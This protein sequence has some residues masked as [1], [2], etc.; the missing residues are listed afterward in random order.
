MWGSNVSERVDGGVVILDHMAV[1]PRTLRVT[2]TRHV[3]EARRSVTT[4]IQVSEEMRDFL[5]GHGTR[6]LMN[7]VSKTFS[8]ISKEEWSAVDNELPL[9]PLH[10]RE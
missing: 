6:F 7:Q 2:G 1:T 8:W 5:S 3:P 9:L 4:R 10:A